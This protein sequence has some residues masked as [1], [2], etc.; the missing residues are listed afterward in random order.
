MADVKDVANLFLSLAEEQANKDL[1]DL[2]T[3]MKLQKMLYFAQCWHLVRY[4][5]LLFSSRIEAWQHGP[6]VPEAY[7][8]YKSNGC[9]PIHAD[10]VRYDALSKTELTTI[11]DVFRYYSRFSASGLRELS[12][13]KGTP[14]D[15]VYQPGEKHIEILPDALKDYYSKQPP[16]ESFADRLQQKINSGAIRVE[17]P[18]RDKNGTAILSNDQED[19]GE[20]DED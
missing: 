16:L 8:I 4:N 12:H 19:W 3:D 18:R 10:P 6:V 5:E 1:G 17:V 2:M 11:L 13:E 15:R 9:N 7:A 20:Y 14:W